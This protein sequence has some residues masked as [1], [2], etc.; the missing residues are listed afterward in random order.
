MPLAIRRLEK[1]DEV[2][3]FDC[4]DPKL[5]EY[6]RC[7]AW[8]NQVRHCVGVTYVALEVDVSNVVVIGF[9]T[10]A[11]SSI[12]NALFPDALG[13]WLPPY[14]HIP[15]VLLARLAVDQRFQCRGVGAQLLAHALHQALRIQ[16]AMGCRG[17]IVDA[18]P[19]AVPWYQK[20][21]FVPFGDP[22]VGAPAETM[23]LDLRTLEVGAARAVMPL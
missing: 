15:V 13:R 5:N 2:K 4:G 14:S 11:S 3:H 7:F 22:P 20:Y 6:Q 8:Q 19:G 18:Y 1:A 23:H 9:Y 10:L 12:A 17:V 16:A 21:G